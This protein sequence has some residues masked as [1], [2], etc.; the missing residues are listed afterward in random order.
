MN[1]KL[2]VVIPTSGKRVDEICL[3]LNGILSMASQILE[4]VVVNQ[5]NPSFQKEVFKRISFT[6]KIRWYNQNEQ[7]KSKALNFAI[8][9]IKGD[10]FIIVDDDVI[11][12]K[13]CFEVILDEFKDKK[14]DMLLGQVKPYIVNSKK[15]LICPSISQISKRRLLTIN[16]LFIPGDQTSG[17]IMAI[18]TNTLKMEHGF[19]EWL[20]PG[21]LIEGGDDWE[22]CYRFVE[23][24]KKI[25]LSPKLIV[26]HNKFLKLND[27]LLLIRKYFI[28]TTALSFY[29]SAKYKNR[30]FLKNWNCHR[31]EYFKIVFNRIQGVNLM[32][33]FCK[34]IF[35]NIFGIIVGLYFSQKD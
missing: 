8:S 28:A 12:T 25:V 21:G 20:G 11:V 19:C 23:L 7:G 14:I 30:K 15:E 26:Y 18:R 3:T 2:S 6:K 17:S 29:L 4:I 22:L 13:K 34:I 31:K 1:T 35:L 16:K 10:I 5:G 9:L 27:F 33:E 24:R 32:I